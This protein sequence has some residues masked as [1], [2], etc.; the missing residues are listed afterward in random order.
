MLSASNPIHH[1]NY[2][3]LTG[4]AGV[5]GVAA[6]LNPC[7]MKMNIVITSTNSLSHIRRISVRQYLVYS[8]MA[9]IF[10]KMLL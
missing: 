5:A 7:M 8:A 3:V 9:H 2:F 6:S 1:D 4:V 10:L